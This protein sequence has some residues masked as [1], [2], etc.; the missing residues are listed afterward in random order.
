MEAASAS[1]G[2]LVVGAKIGLTLQ[3]FVSTCVDAPLI[4]ESVNSKI[5][6]VRFALSKL[7]PFIKHDLQ[8]Y[9]KYDSPAAMT[10]LGLQ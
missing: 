1:V 3:T 2:L 9:N 7:Q 6:E 5:R 10:L 8:P 4:A